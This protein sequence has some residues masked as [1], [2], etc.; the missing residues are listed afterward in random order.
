LLLSGPSSGWSSDTFAN[1][2]A[3]VNG[4]LLRHRRIS[5]AEVLWAINSKDNTDLF[6]RFHPQDD[7]TFADNEL[8]IGFMIKPGT[9]SVV[10][11][12]DDVLEFV[13]RDNL[14]GI[15]EARAFVHYGVEVV[16]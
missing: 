15:S 4:L 5:T 10:I 11:T 9:A 3:L 6:G 1:T 13:V 2:T 16:E 8:L 12:N 14:S 7:I